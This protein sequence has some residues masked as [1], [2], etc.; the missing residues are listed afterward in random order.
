MNFKGGRNVGE[1]KTV[2]GSQFW[3]GSENSEL[4]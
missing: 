3:H 4:H 1:M 2:M